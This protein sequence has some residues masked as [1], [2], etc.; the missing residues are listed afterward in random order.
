MHLQM[1]ARFIKNK[2]N[3]SKRNTQSEKERER[4]KKMASILFV[5]F[6]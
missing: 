6:Q 1:N 4:E 2:R 5:L 3:D